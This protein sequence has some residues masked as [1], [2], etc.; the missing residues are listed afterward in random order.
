MMMALLIW[1]FTT[2]HPFHVSVCEVVHSQKARALQVSCR[3]FL[4]DLEL[5][6]RKQTGDGELNL[7]G[8]SIQT[9]RANER[10]FKES[11]QFTINGQP[12]SYVYLGGE[13]EED[14]MWCFLEVSNVESLHSV[15]IANTFLTDLYDDQQNIVHF[16]IGT[17]KR[18]F[19]LT[20]EETQAA[21]YLR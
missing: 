7:V 12:A 9:H 11:L 21:V 3:V 19:I 10:Y 1:I 15:T 6:L 13:I 16:R 2:L 4:D 17:D 8:D 14:V 18:S 5:A 20:K